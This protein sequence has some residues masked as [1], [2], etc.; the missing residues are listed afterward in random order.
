[1]TILFSGCSNTAGIGLVTGQL[2]YAQMVANYLDEDFDNISVAGRDNQDIFVNTLLKIKN[3]RYTKVVVQWTFT[4]RLGINAYP[5]INM[6]SMTSTQLMSDAGI[7]TS[8]QLKVL[9]IDVEGVRTYQRNSILLTGRHHSWMNMFLYTDIIITYCML[10]G[11]VPVF[12]DLALDKKF[13]ELIQSKNYSITELPDSVKNIFTQQ[14]AP[15]PA[16][17]QYIDSFIQLHNPDVWVNFSN[18]W[19]VH[20]TDRATDSLH[21]GP[22]SHQWMADQLIFHLT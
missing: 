3:N 13:T 18:P 4:E 14:L 5:T 19:K 1:M 15:D 16:I 12:I 8:Q 21:P 22:K 11:I 20:W 17:Q 2:N 9:G 6:G 7:F 10:N